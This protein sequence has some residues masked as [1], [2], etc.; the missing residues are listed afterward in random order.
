MCYP[1]QFFVLQCQH[2]GALGKQFHL[3]TRQRVCG[4][5]VPLGAP[6]ETHNKDT[7]EVSFHG[8]VVAQS[9]QTQ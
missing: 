4:G 6:A 3:D 5:E 7:P 2:P 9:S 1:S 8:S